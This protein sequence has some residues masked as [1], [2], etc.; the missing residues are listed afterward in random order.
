VRALRRISGLVRPRTL[1]LPPGITIVARRTGL[2]FRGDATAL[3]ALAEWVRTLSRSR[4]TELTV[5]DWRLLASDEVPSEP[6]NRIVVLPAHAWNIAASKF[7]EVATS[8][9]KS[10]FDFGD[11]GYLIPRPQPDVGVE[12]IGQPFPDGRAFFRARAYGTS[13][14]SRVAE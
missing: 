8:W 5:N 2:R 1:E 6:D 10:P 9:E 13:A 12:L 3:L 11:C 7:A 4:V 14:G